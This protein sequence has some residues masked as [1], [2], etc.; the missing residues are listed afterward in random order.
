MKK[1]LCLAVLMSASPLMAAEVAGQVGFMSGVL[2]AQRADGTVKVLA[3]KSQVVEGDTLVTSGNG[4]AQ[5]KMNDGTQMTLRPDSNLKIEAFQFRKDAPQAD[6]AVFRLLRGGFRTLTGLIGKR[7]NPDAYKLRAA[8][9]TI[10]IRGTNFTTRLCND[11]DCSDDSSRPAGPAPKVVGRV[12]LLQ[13]AMVAKEISGDVRKLSLGSPVY[14]GDT[15]NTDPKSQSVVAFRDESRI[16]LQES[17]S[18]YVEKFKY[19]KATAQES[20]VLRLLKGSVRVVTGWIGR[21]NHDNYRFGV[22]GATIG[23]RGTGFDAWCNAGCASGSGNSGATQDKPLDGAGVYVWAGSVV[24]I[25]PNGSFDVALQQAAMIARDTGKPVQIMVVPKAVL[26]NGAPRPD[27]IPVDFEKEFG[28]SGEGAGV[29]VTVHD[30]KI[31]VTLDGK[32]LNLGAGESGFASDEE[33]MRLS[34]MPNFM[35]VPD[36]NSDPN[37]GANP[38]GCVVAP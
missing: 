36:Q 33:L 20:A 31:I 32:V 21:A 1:I 18:F 8:S 17:S 38:N 19:N 10:G 25:T 30:G 15:L 5:V 16:T 26:E 12:M 22:A 27:S 23:I 35:G 34:S 13:G 24:L 37:P 2:V 9:A 11:K 3:P 7:G 4:Y 28:A 14:E 6:N 29:Y